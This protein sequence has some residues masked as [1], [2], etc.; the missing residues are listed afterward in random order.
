MPYHP[1]YQVY[2]PGCAGAGARRVMP[3]VVQ[4]SGPLPRPPAPLELDEA[5]G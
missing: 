3:P 2:V 5:E 4:E 1:A